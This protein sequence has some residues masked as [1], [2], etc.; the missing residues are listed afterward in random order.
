MLDEFLNIS[1]KSIKNK[2]IRSWL[3]VIGIVI[4][5]AAIVSL[6][7][8]GQGLQYAINQQFAILGPNLVFIMP[9]G[10]FG[11]GGAA[12][13]LTD[14]DIRLIK[15]VK[16]VELAGGIIGKIAKVK[17]QDK[18]VYPMVVGV[19]SGDTQDILLEGTGV[20]IE[21]GQQRFKPGDT[22]K[23]AV[24]YEYWGGKAF[25]QP[26][27]IGDKITINDRRFT[28]SAFVSRIGN[29]DDDSHLYITAEDAKNLFSVKDDYIEIMI[30][31]KDG[32]NVK[33]VADKIKE[34]MRQDRGL[35]KGEEDFNVIT[36]EQVRS[37]VGTILDAVQAIVAGIAG[38]SLIVGG[39]GIMNTMYT[40]VLERT[41]EIG[42]MK[43]IGAKNSNIV[44][45]F[46][47]ESGLIGLIGGVVG[48]LI[49]AT[50]GKI[51]EY[52]A[53]VQLD[54]TIVQAAIT[55]QLIIGALLFSFIVGCISGFLPAR[56]A[57]NLKPVD[58]L[59]YE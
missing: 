26:L 14:H 11:P 17:F 15:G 32:Y 50:L 53:V 55:P 3:T 36:L 28:V 45:M 51:V 7:S 48:C 8:L 47:M 58:A 59:R 52:I 46:M 34:K 24:G 54:Q 9:G 43:A 30:R 13:K 23:V 40:S 6:I 18:I 25:D 44:V 49:G 20:K 12:S 10:L 4:G 27:K 56:Q 22:N 33:V 5:I 19:D 1:L 2:G 16:G 35:K 38:I 21:K 39:V 42:V 57:A 29:P 41:R 37:S 31:I